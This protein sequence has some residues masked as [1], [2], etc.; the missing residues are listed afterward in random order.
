MPAAVFYARRLTDD[1]MRATTDMVESIANRIPGASEGL[2]PQTDVFARPRLYSSGLGTV[3]D[4]FGVFRVRSAD[5]E[6][7]DRELQRLQEAGVDY[8]LTKPQRSIEDISLSNQPHI[9]WRYVAMAGNE[10]KDEG[11]GLG[12]KDALN[13]MVEGREP[14]RIPYKGRQ[15]EHFSKIEGR[16]LDYTAAYK[17]APTDEM[18][19]R[20]IDELKDYYRRNAKAHVLKTEP[21]LQEKL[22]AKEDEKRRAKFGEREAPPPSFQ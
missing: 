14:V 22:K 11:T 1:Q 17:A 8:Y 12:F 20:L 6:P 15:F 16:H 18:R 4:A 5:Q 21:W 7:I 13:R 10:W 3:Y 19:A 2:A 9:Y